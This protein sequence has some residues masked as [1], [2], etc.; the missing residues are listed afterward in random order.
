MWTTILYGIAQ[1]TMWVLG[2]MEDTRSRKIK[3]SDLEIREELAKA[4]A[5]AAAER[6]RA[7]EEVRVNAKSGVYWAWGKWPNADTTA[8]VD[9]VEEFDEL[10]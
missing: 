1:F 6:A 5:A 7:E 10:T 4:A 9:Y 2:R 3:K 8:D